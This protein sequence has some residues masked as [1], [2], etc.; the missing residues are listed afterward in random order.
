MSLIR[1]ELAARLRRWR[2]P[3][4]WA[5]LLLLGLWLVWR[6]Y[7][8]LAAL[9]FAAGLLA[10]VAG[11][12]LLRPAL[13]RLRLASD[14]AE[15]VV[16][17]VEARVG[18]FGPYGGGFIDL[19]ALTAVDVRAGPPRAWVLRTD[20]AILTIPFGARDAG[21]LFDALSAL[22]GIDFDAAVE[23]EGPRTRRI[24]SREPPRRGAI[25]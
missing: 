12:G 21:A 18:Y 8:S 11:A 16:S 7:R 6:G 3:L 2:E 4:V 19:P 23:D 10:A 20:E 17:V 9:P 13:K 15:G 5:A 24:W 1:P 22:P 25:R 14:P